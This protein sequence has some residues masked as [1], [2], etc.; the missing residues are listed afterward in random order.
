MSTRVEGHPSGVEQG[1]K[2]RAGDHRLVQ[3]AALYA[4]RVSRVDPSRLEVANFLEA[5]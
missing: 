2:R 4:Y 5:N 1:G 3:R